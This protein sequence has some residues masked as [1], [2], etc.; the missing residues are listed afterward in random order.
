MLQQPAGRE[1]G[2]G[3]RAPRY[4]YHRPEQTLRYQLVEEDYFDFDVVVTGIIGVIHLHKHSMR[5]RQGA[6]QVR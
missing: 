5:W 1:A 3:E 6:D 4:Q 2:R